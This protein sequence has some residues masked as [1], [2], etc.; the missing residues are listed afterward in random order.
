MI[1]Y[2]SMVERIKERKTLAK[3]LAY[4]NKI[5]TLLNY[6]SYP[7]FI[8]V[9]W[10]LQAEKL[11]WYVLVPAISFVA[12]SVF[13]HIYNAPRPYEKFD[14]EPIGK[15]KAKSGKSFPSR[16][17]FSAFIIGF[18]IFDFC[19]PIG[20]VF[21]I[22]SVFLAVARVLCGVHFVKDVLVGSGF[23]VLVYLIMLLLI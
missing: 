7:V 5:L 20:I 6:I 9:A 15:S 21:L 17:T 22:L 12:L 13:R 23:A 10:Y 18:M 16:H 3:M 2:L 4:S 19:L 14:Y 11:I 1:N 8:A